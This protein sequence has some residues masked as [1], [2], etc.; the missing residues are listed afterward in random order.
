METTETVVPE[1]KRQVKFTFEGLIATVNV[2]GSDNAEVFDIEE[3]DEDIKLQL[4][5][6]GFKQKLSDFRAGDKLREEEKL[7]AIKECYEML[8]EGNFRQASVKAK[9][10]S[11]EEQLEGWRQMS[12]EEKKRA[13]LL[14][15]QA[16]ADKLEKASN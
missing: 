16:K 4:L 3:L 14:I 9:G 13:A 7:E 8:A 5:Q 12:D 11:F 1:K 10:P 2:S 15:G 6:Y